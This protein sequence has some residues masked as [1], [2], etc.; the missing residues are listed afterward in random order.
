MSKFTNRQTKNPN[1]PSKSTN[2]FFFYSIN[3]L[4]F[5]GAGPGGLDLVDWVLTSTLTNNT[6]TMECD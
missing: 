3:L 5:S 4:F 6:W 2:W 1:I